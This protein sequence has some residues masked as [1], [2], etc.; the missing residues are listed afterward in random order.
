MTSPNPRIDIAA[1]AA[2]FPPESD[3]SKNYGWAAMAASIFLGFGQEKLVEDLVLGILEQTGDDVEEQT[4][5]FRKVREAMLKAS[6]LVGFPRV[7]L[8]S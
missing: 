8:V 2:I 6:A 3:Y 7:C 4:K 1:L 5:A